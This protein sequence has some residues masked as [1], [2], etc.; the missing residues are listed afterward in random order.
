V[1]YARR[2]ARFFIVDPTIGVNL[3]VF[4]GVPPKAL[5]DPATAVQA[6]RRNSLHESHGPNMLIIVA[7]FQDRIDD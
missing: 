7:M 3:E 4:I 2:S 6:K 1:Q 5:E